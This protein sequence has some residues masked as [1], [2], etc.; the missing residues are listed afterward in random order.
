MS[1][2]LRTLGAAL[3]LLLAA[4]APASAGDPVLP[5]TKVG[6]GQRCTAYSVIQGTE[7][8]SF[9]AEVVDVV[10]G[11]AAVEA[12]RILLRFSGPAIDRTG[13]GPGFSG[14]P[15]YCPDDDGTRKVAGAISESVGEYGGTLAL[16]T[17]IEA[18]LGQPVD[19]PEG[20]RPMAPEARASRRPLAAP[21][22][23][24]GL[25][26]PVGRLFGRAAARGGRV[27]YSAPARPRAQAFP[28]Q[29]LRPGAA[30]AAGLSSGDVTAGSV[31]TVA[32]VDGDRVWAFGHP[33]D[34]A[35]RRS[36]FLQ[37]AYVFATVNNPVQ[38]E[39][40][41]TYKLAT[42]GHDVGILSGDGLS[43]VAGRLGALPDRFPMRVTAR[44][45]DTGRLRSHQVQIAD[46]TAIGL[47]TGT[48]A[49]ALVG[50]AA[51]GQAATTILGSSPSR[52]TGDMCVKITVRER[53]E[54]FAFCN[55]YV[56][57]GASEEEGDLGVGG[58]MVGDFVEAVTALDEFNFATLHVT[59]VEVGM[60]VRRGLR[61]AFLLEGSAPDAVRRGRTVRVRLKLQEVRGT[62]VTRTVRVRV[63]R[64]MPAGERMLT[65][66][67]APADTGG[68]LEID[69]SELLFGAEE[70][71]DGGEDEGGDEAGPR[72][73]Q[74]LGRV[75][76]RLE[77]YDG[78]QASFE[79]P[80]EDDASLEDLGEE[81]GSPESIARKRR[82]VLRDPD[83]R[84]SG[85]VRIPV[86]VE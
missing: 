63:P 83:L 21:V 34:G 11:D 5:L 45:K 17:P 55:R 38:V 70:E 52:Q 82:K 42:P 6:K 74:A 66:E 77:R 33:L 7:I 51:V 36:L 26:A 22:S 79:P 29:Q 18:V 59:G 3:A 28:V 61:Q 86:Y 39:G 23:F 43:A 62:P 58:P 20:T 84:L 73:L 65:L 9:D 76:D 46:E 48:S 37:D 44:D 72:T 54:P 24:G 57:R 13:V 25:S 75:I 81:P 49:L 68:N 1:F 50:G 78:V 67:G 64:G 19:P 4:A 31:G 60:R 85:R 16:A 80:G 27:V 32:Y 40:A 10:A 30:M 15:V 14:S 53:R 69:L 35:G 47:P 12:P 41:S 8:S 56:A 71:Q 2:P